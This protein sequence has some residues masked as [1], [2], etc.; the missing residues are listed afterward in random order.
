MWLSKKVLTFWS[1]LLISIS[2]SLAQGE[3]TSSVQFSQNTNIKY[4]QKTP[5]DRFQLRIWTSQAHRYYRHPRSPNR[6]YRQW[7]LIRLKT[8]FR[9]STI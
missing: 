5:P 1:A 7:I 3:F 8:A 4:D 9:L 2:S 6:H